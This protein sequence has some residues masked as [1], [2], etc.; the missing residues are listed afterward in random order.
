MS[1]STGIT[2]N[3]RGSSVQL[4][5]GPGWCTW[6]AGAGTS[7]G[8]LNAGQLLAPGQS[9]SVLRLAT[10]VTPGWSGVM[11]ELINRFQQQHQ[12]RVEMFSSFD[13]YEQMEHGD[14][15][16]VIA[17][18]KKDD[19]RTSTRRFVMTGLG[20]WPK[21][22]FA[23]SAVIVG[24]SHDP[25][26]IR[27]E[28]DAARAV[29]KIAAAGEHLRFARVPEN[30]F[31]FE[32]LWHAAGGESLG[33][34]WIVEVDTPHDAGDGSKVVDA[35]RAGHYFVWGLIPFLKWKERNSEVAME[36]MVWDEQLFHHVMC[37]VVVRQEVFPHANVEAALL[38]EQHLL[39]AESQAY[40]HS[41]RDHGH[42]GPLWFPRAVDNI[43]H[44]LYAPYPGE[45]PAAENFTSAF[46]CP[47]DAAAVPASPAA[48]GDGAATR[49]AAAAVPLPLLRSVSSTR[50]TGL[51]VR[52]DVDA[53]RFTGSPLHMTTR[54]YNGTFPGP[55]LRVRRGDSIRIKL[56]NNLASGPGDDRADEAHPSPNVTNLH[57]HGMHV[58]ATAPSPESCG[59]DVTC[60]VRPQQSIT[61]QY[62]VDEDHPSGTYWYHPH[63]HGTTAL[64]VGGLMAGMLIVEDEPEETP[65]E[66][67]SMVEVLLVLQMQ[68]FAS[69]GVATHETVSAQLHDTL[70]M[71]VSGPRANFILANGQ[72]QPTVSLVANQY[73]RFRILNANA[74]ATLELDIPRG[75]HC[76]MDVLAHD[77]VYLGRPAHVNHLL[78][79]VP[80]SRVDLA[81]R[82]RRSGSYVLRSNPDRA[83]DAALGRH[84]RLA[85]DI[86]F[87]AVAEPQPGAAELPLPARLPAL[88]A[89]MQEDLLVSTPD[90]A[91]SIILGDV[92]N[93]DDYQING[94]VYDGS[95]QRT[96]PLGSLQEW[97][98]TADGPNMHPFHAHLNHFQIVHVDGPAEYA[99][100]VGVGQWRDTIP[101]PADGAAVTV[102]FRAHRW[103]GDLPYHCHILHHADRGMAARLAIVG[104]ATSEC[105]DVA[106]GSTA[107]PLAS[108]YCGSGTR[109]HRETQL[110]ISDSGGPRGAAIA[111][112]IAWH[113]FRCLARRYGPEVCRARLSAIGGNSAT[114]RASRGK[115][116]R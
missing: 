81:L 50:G 84:A 18:Y 47:Q 108:Q 82:C 86:L 95:I 94:Q 88:P 7:L 13:V 68:Y 35:F 62:T 48:A 110:C 106:L 101:I 92:P 65:Y 27:G 100:L 45:D 63:V 30:E 6:V 77:G 8:R 75:S 109:W 14:A 38:F 114:P 59:D 87:L 24:P 74:V 76:S 111:A 11:D 9:S 32:L 22:L 69:L 90:E 2:A 10:V 89:H 103:C 49:T 71:D 93:S 3:A 53:A 28:R 96:I 52:L 83:R 112:A 57:L 116:P 72:H 23:N 31:T 79:L 67:A 4:L 54:C 113:V 12:I 37:S 102:R 33:R 39:S 73:A 78:V 1:T 34:E 44:P 105:P 64:Q 36:A 58:P 40:V 85:Q 41:F 80:G 5:G 115:A 25:A 60:M 104:T 97:R 17:H 70:N 61:Y 21:M 55:V 26:K 98:V 91:S 20:R 29:A 51:D 107:G 19:G 56:V 43:G 42:D 16:M 15:D 66:L 99:A 46:L